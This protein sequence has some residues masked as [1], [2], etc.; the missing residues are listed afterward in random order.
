M[1]RTKVRQKLQKDLD[2]LLILSHKRIYSNPLSMALNYAI[3]EANFIA[4]ITHNLSHLKI[5]LEEM[6]NQIREKY[7][8]L[9][10]IE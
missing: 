1:K 9:E 3:D 7:N 6:I 2:I 10:K 8:L 5:K 4:D